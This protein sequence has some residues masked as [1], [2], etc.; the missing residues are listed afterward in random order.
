MAEGYSET[1]HPHIFITHGLSGSGKTTL[2]GTHM[3]RLGAI[4]IRSDIERKRL[5]ALK[6]DEKSD[7]ANIYTDDASRK[8]YQRLADLAVAITQGGYPVIVDATFLEQNERNRFRSLAEELGVP[9][10]I[11]HFHA[12][13]EV[14]SRRIQKRV[15]IG[16]DASE[17]DLS[18]LQGQINR[19]RSLGEKE[20]AETIVIDTEA[21]HPLDAIHAEL[22]DYF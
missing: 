6:S 9:F 5:F 18:V 2:T 15:E 14:L 20:M 7:S 22:H 4:R 11:L 17:A 21:E 12:R 13:P 19:Y 8:T 1:D 10:T 16:K 3:Q